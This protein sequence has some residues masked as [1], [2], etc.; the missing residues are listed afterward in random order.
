MSD[1]SFKQKDCTDGN[2]EYAAHEELL[3]CSTINLVK[4]N[5]IVVKYGTSL[6]RPALIVADKIGYPCRFGLVARFLP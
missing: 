6:M 2:S 4:V 1:K 3:I 5:I